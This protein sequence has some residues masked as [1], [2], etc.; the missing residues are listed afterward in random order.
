M[1]GGRGQAIWMIT[2]C[3]VIAIVQ[4]GIT[5][6]GVPAYAQNVVYGVIIMV[7]I[8]IT[9]DRKSRLQIVK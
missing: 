7:A 9:A 3:A 8:I 6:I 5:V 4:N 2:G 1:S